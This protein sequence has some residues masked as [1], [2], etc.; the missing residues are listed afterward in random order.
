MDNQALPYVNQTGEERKKNIIPIVIIIII[1]IIIVGM[2]VLRQPKK[3]NQTEIVVINKKEPTPTEKPKIDKKS[4]K[5]Q[6]LNGTGTPGQAAV[7]ADALKKAGF[8]QDNI[9]TDNAS[10]FNHTAT[11]VSVKASFEEVASDIKQIL[12]DMFDKVE[13]NTSKL[14]EKNEFDVIITTGGKKFEENKPSPTLTPV[15]TTIN[16]TPTPSPTTPTATPSSTLIPSPTPT[17]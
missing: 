4:V 1:G 10:D 16:E 7:V 17:P 11:A 15:V 5:V 6:I 13:I 8:N 2:F 3:S 12:A 14:D 9:K